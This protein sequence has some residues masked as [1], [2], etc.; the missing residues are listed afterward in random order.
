MGRWRKT[1]KSLTDFYMELVIYAVVGEHKHVCSKAML[2]MLL[3]FP[4]LGL[5][6]LLLLLFQLGVG[7]KLLQ[8]R[9][10]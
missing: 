3:Q 9:P 5:G 1:P 4:G 10:R 2:M 7:F 8:S 6:L